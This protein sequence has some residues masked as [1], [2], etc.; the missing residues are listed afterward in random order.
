MRFEEN[1]TTNEIRVLGFDKQIRRV[2]HLGWTRGLLDQQ[3]IQHDFGGVVGMSSL[4]PT[5]MRRLEN[6]AC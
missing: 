1:R 3:K 2:H 6:K 5:L 4:Y